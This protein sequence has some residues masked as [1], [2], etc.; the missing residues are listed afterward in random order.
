MTNEL[1]ILRY[2]VHDTQTRRGIKRTFTPYFTPK[3]RAHITEKYTTKGIE[4]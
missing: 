3:G 2:R 4:N 1:G